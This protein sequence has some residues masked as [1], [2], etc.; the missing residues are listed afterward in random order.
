MAIGD[1]AIVRAALDALVTLLRTFASPTGARGSV[2]LM[3]QRTMHSSLDNVTDDQVR[4]SMDLRY[5]PVG[6]P[7]GRPAFAPAG[8]VAR[9]RAHPEQVLAD[10][11]EWAR[12]WLTLRDELAEKTLAAPMFNR[13]TADA[14][15][16][17]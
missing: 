6:Q 7:T 9:S 12:R 17:A 1:G 11:A 3:T 15:V 4:I 13:W 5:Q 2:L 8:F 10:P 14:A 16:C